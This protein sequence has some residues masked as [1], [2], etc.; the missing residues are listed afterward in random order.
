GSFGQAMVPSGASTGEFEALELRDNDK[1][2]YR[3]K[4]VTKAVDNVKN[5][6]APNLKGQLATDQKAVD[7][8]LV[9]L[10]GTPNKGS[11]GANAI[12]G[13]SLATA[14]AAAAYSKLELY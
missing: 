9:E 13:V 8:I 1:S 6:I 10:D 5:I 14:H 4:G 12:L 2:R 3:G 7:A 11:L